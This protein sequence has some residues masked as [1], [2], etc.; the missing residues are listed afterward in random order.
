MSRHILAR[1]LAA[2]SVAALALAAPPAR[3]ASGLKGRVLDRAGDPVPGAAVA[4]TNHASRA[5]I[6]VLSDENGRFESPP[7]WAGLYT[8]EATLPGVDARATATVEVEA[9]R[10]LA[11]DLR[12]DL[13]MVHESAVVVGRAPQDSVESRAIR[14]SLARDAGESLTRLPG[15]SRVRKGAIANDVVVR[16]FKGENLS[17][18]IDGARLH[19]ACPGKMDP[20][21]FH[22]DFAEIERIEVGKGPFDVTTSGALGGAVNIVTRQPAPGWHGGL[23]LGV[24]S[25]DLVAPSATGSYGGERWSVS[26]GYSYR[27][28]DPYEDGDGRL[29]TETTNY[30]P[31]DREARAYD[32]S[33]GWAGL[34]LAP[35]PGHRLELQATVQRVDTALYPYLQMDADWDDADRLRAAYTAQAPFA[36]A[37][38]LQASVSWAGIDHWMTDA[39][40]TTGEGKPRGYS[41]AT[42]ANASVGEFQASL[43][44]GRLTVGVEAYRRNWTAETT[45]WVMPLRTYRSQDSLP[46]VDTDSAGI[47]ATW[48]Q[49]LGEELELDLGARLDRAETSASAQQADTGLYAAFHGTRQLSR[50]DTLPGASATLTWRPDGRWTV[51]AGL[52]TSTR[53]PSAEERYY[54]LQRATSSW[55]GN[56]ALDPPR[57]TEADLGAS[58]AEGRVRAELSVFRSWI[59]DYVT[60]Y[61]AERLKPVPGVA[62]PVAKSYANVDAAIWGGELALSIV[63]TPRLTFMLGGSFTQGRQ[64]P[65]PAQNI[66]S[67][68]LPEML[69][70]L[71]RAAVRYD[72]GAWFAE[73]AG[74]FSGAQDH[75]DTDLNEVPTPGWGILNLRGGFSVGPFSLVLGI[76]NVF[77]RLYRE[78]LSYARDPFRSGALV[79]EPGRNATLSLLL[80]R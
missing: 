12:L 32:V 74:I 25:F 45:L 1:V 55:V 63:A 75:V 48:E 8:L 19:G 43:V 37:D 68:Y 28:Q 73:A 61:Q 47:F 17:V 56:P 54:A 36:G 57:N 23:Q 3:A 76:D 79:W 69:P 5:A 50:A 7:V 35:A 66:D 64:D 49:P 80:R 29:F 6:T 53:V 67:E 59:A 21:A 78:A 34:A 10:V 26:G 60:V 9:D 14:E 11:V 13:D 52:G 40:R 24:G 15:V 44:L 46:D 72:A 62:T 16:S 58:F 4:I 39:R 41:M 30:L 18:T 71:G 77:N 70:P 42:R 51:F 38:L 27:R 2:A 22:I 33:T 65:E 20:P 31:A